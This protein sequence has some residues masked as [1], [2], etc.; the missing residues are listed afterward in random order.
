MSHLLVSDLIA[1]VVRIHRSGACGFKSLR[2]KKAAD[3]GS[4]SAAWRLP[5]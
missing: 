3:P 1:L 4:G 5:S 2:N